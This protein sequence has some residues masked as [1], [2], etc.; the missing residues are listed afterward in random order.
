[1]LSLV[2]AALFWGC[3]ANTQRADRKWRFEL[4]SFDFAVGAAVMA[5][6][7]AMT[8][9]NAGNSNSFTFEDILTVASK[10]NMAVAFGGGAIYCL[11][12]VMILAGVVLAGMSTALPV[13]AGMGLLMG[14]AFGGAPSNGGLVY[15]GA[16][17]ALGAVVAAAM[18]Q[19]AAV[20]A[21]PVKRGMH[22]AWK[23]YVLSCLGG[24]IIG[25]ALAVVE[26]GRGGD[27]GVGAYGAAVFMSMGMLTTTPLVALYFLN[28]PVQGE[29]SSLSAYF[30]GT[31]TQHLLGLLGGVVWSVG[32]TAFLA[33]AGGTHKGASK[34]LGNEALFLGGALFGAICGFLIWGE[35]AGA[36]KAKTILLGALVLLAGGSAMVFMG[37]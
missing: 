22:P 14:V 4:Y 8:V 7:L 9:G 27:I 12:N 36:P 6:L 28:L 25:I 3:W 18:A 20:L 2:F 11:G 26:S 15:G 34:F 21:A 23:G 32:T 13:A 24:V 17:A 16:G 19:K 31:K 33:S 5:L 29:A 10:R 30:T 1:M 35:Q 37:A